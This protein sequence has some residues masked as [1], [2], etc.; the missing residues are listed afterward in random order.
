M[1]ATLIY[2]LF[3][4]NG[5]SWDGSSDV[6]VS[7]TQ[8]RCET[9]KAQLEKVHGNPKSYKCLTLVSTGVQS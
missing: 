9:I 4:F 6:V 2:V 8:G 5:S 1:N 3:A 7:P